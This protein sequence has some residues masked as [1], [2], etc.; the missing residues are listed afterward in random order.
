M[1]IKTIIDYLA[2]AIFLI[3]AIAIPLAFLEL[4]AQFFGKSLVLGMY[5]PGRLL[6]LAALLLIFVIA[7]LLWQIRDELRSNR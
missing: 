7:V 5:S 6:E 4:G 1:D 2:K 3:A